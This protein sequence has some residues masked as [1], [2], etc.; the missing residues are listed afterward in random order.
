MRKLLSTLFFFTLIMG[1]FAFKLADT[2]ATEKIKWYTWEE[3]VTANKKEKRKV[4]VDIYTSWCGWCKRM[5]K[6]TFSD[7]RVV[8]Y[9]NEHFYAVKLDAEQKEAITFGGYTF[10]YK[11]LRTK[12]YHELAAALLDNKLS[13]PTTVFLTEDFKVDQRL[14]GYLDAN[15]MLAV[16][17]Y[18]AEE[19]EKTNPKPWKQYE[20]EF[21]AKQLRKT[22][23]GATIETIDTKPQQ[24]PR[25]DGGLSKG[26]SDDSSRN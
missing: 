6:T 5:D 11:P 26:N 19:K 1:S 16:L 23:K 18:L 13:Y 12:G 4:F 2:T 15:K 7:H 25:Q 17:T 22:T 21:E 8:A 24:R 10:N 14:P 20:Q 9:L 3:A